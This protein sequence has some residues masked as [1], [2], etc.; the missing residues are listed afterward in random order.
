LRAGVSLL[1]HLVGA[2]EYH[3]W[4][5]ET[6]RSRGFEI[7]NKFAIYTRQLMTKLGSIT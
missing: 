6:E 2:G 5:C 3:R 7:D 1:N 4:R